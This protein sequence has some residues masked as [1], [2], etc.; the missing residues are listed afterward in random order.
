MNAYLKE[1]LIILVGT[2]FILL[3]TVVLILIIKEVI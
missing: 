3:T 1:T 2:G